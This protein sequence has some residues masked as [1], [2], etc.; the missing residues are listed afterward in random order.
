MK[1]LLKIGIISAAAIIFALLIVIISVVHELYTGIV[2]IGSTQAS[3]EYAGYELPL[4]ITDDM[5]QALF[6]NQ[7]EFGIPVSSGLA[8]I[9]QESGFGTYGPHGESGQGLSG[10]AYNYKNL[11]GIKYSSSDKFASGVKSFTTGEHTSTGDSYTIVA[12]FSVYPDYAAC[13]NQRA[14]MLSNPNWSYY[15]NTKDYL[16]RCDGKYTVSLA[17]SYVGGIKAGGWATDVSYVQNL[18]KHMTT[19]NLYRFDNM[20]WQ[21]YKAGTTNN[22]DIVIVG[23]GKLCNPCPS[24]YISSEFGGRKSPGGIGST[25]HKGRD[26][27]ASAGTPIYASDDGKVIVST[28]NVARGNY[29]Q[30]DHGN[31]IKTIY[32]HNS[33]N[34]VSVGQSVKKGQIIAYVG[35]TGYSTGPHLH[36]EVWVN[37]V[38][39]DPRNYL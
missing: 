21:E 3:G 8:Q 24:A 28:F 23:T 19:Y 18:I 6:E 37:D 4:F 33:S 5:L 17:N 25:N 15:R 16:N 26:Y 14:S 7:T 29:V 35:S 1:K 2:A 11:F 31:G 30:I 34:A 13:I 22:G 27:A 36:F 38:P 20:T 10:L 9:I 12:G 39:V 32:Q